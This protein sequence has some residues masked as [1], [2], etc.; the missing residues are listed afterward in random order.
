MFQIFT[1]NSLEGKLNPGNGA[2]TTN[3]PKSETCVEESSLNSGPNT[4][5]VKILKQNEPL[6][7]FSDSFILRFKS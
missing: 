2:S 3:D 6:V 5:V 1:A 7:R 4:R